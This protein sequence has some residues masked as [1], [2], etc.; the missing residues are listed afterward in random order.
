[1]KNNKTNYEEAKAHRLYPP[2]CLP[3]KGMVTKMIKRL[4]AIVLISTMI[5]ASVDYSVSAEASNYDGSIKYQAGHAA[6][7]KEP[8]KSLESLEVAESLESLEAQDTSKGAEPLQDEKNTKGI[9]PITETPNNRED[10]ATTDVASDFINIMSLAEPDISVPVKYGEDQ[11]NYPIAPYYHDID[12][13]ES[14]ELSSGALNLN[15]V[16]FSLP[17]KDGF[18]FTLNRRYDSSQSNSYVLTPYYETQAP[19]NT[20]WYVEIPVTFRYKRDSGSTG[21]TTFYARTA[22]NL[23]GYYYSD[24]DRARRDRDDLGYFLTEDFVPGEYF[25]LPDGEW[26][27][28]DRVNSFAQ[29]WGGSNDN[30]I[31]TISNK[32]LMVSYLRD[33][34]HDLNTY[35][36][37]QGWNFG[38]PSVEVVADRDKKNN[39]FT[40]NSYLHVGDGRR[41]RLDYSRSGTTRIYHMMYMNTSNKWHNY[42]QLQRDIEFTY[43]TSAAARYPGANHVLAYKDGKKAYFSATEKGTSTSTYHFEDFKLLAMEDRFGNAIK[44][45]LVTDGST[46]GSGTVT[47]SLG[48]LITAT[49]TGSN[50]DYTIRWSFP[51]ENNNPNGASISYRVV[52]N[53]LSEYTD[54]LGNVTRYSYDFQ[55]SPSQYMS[56]VY[57]DK[58]VN[59]WYYPLES[60]THASGLISNYSYTSRELMTNRF[61]G[62]YETA[63][64]LAERSDTDGS[65]VTNRQQ[66][67]YESKPRVLDEIEV[68]SP[69]WGYDSYGFAISTFTEKATIQKNTTREEYLFRFA[70]PT[71]DVRIFEGSS[72]SP[73]ETRT[74]EYN[75]P[76]TV[77]MPTLER[78]TRVEESGSSIVSETRN[79]YDRF[80]NATSSTD[81]M[82][83]ITT[84]TYDA[85]CS[86]PTK[87]TYKKDSATDITEDYELNSAGT[88]VAKKTVT[89]GASIK[90]RTEYLYTGNNLTEMRRY[91]SSDAN[92]APVDNL[93][94]STT[95]VATTYSYANNNA[96]LPNATYNNVFLTGQTVSG[97]TDADGAQA[98]GTAT[99]GTITETYKRDAWG[100]IIEQTDPN[101]NTTKYQL[102]RLGRATL[103]TNPDGST[104]K[105]A[106][107]LTSSENKVVATDENGNDTTYNYNKA[108][109]IIQVLAGSVAMSDFTYDSL[110]RLSR[111]TSYAPSVSYEHYLYDWS[112][113]VKEIRLNTSTAIS[114][115]PLYRETYSYTGMAG[116][117]RQTQKTVEGTSATDPS[118]VTSQRFDLLGRVV[119]ESIGP[120]NYAYTYDSLGN[121]L[122]ATDPLNRSKNFTYDYAGRATSESQTNAGATTYA[123]STYDHL[124]NLASAADFN[125]NAAA[126]QYDRLGRLIVET[127]PLDTTTKSVKKYYYDAAGNVIKDETRENSA[128]G[129]LLSRREYSYDARNRLLDA[130]NYKNASE[131]DTASYQYYP[132]GQISQLTAGGNTTSYEYNRF[133][134]ATKIRDAKN[135][136]EVYTYDQRG[137]LTSKTFRNGNSIEYGYDALGRVVKE[138]ARKSGASS[139]E[140]TTAYSYGLTGALL[141]QSNANLATSFVYNS[142]GQLTRQTDGDATKTYTYDAVG[143]RETFAL[144]QGSTVLSLS[145]DYDDLNRLSQALE[146]SA[147]IA[148]YTYDDN[149]NVKTY[150]NNKNG[151]TTTYSYNRAN[152]VTNIAPN[153][154]SLPSYAYEYRADGNQT[155]KTEALAGSPA[156]VT[157][158]TYDM[159]GRLTSEAVGELTTAYAFDGAGNRDTVTVSG[160]ESYSIKYEYDSLNRL[161]SSAKSEGGAQIVT[162][163]S[164]DANGNTL[165]S[166]V[167]TF[168]PISGA[169]ASYTMEE[170]LGAIEAF[171]YNARDQLIR[172]YNGEAVAE[173][174]YRPD[175]MRHEKTVGGTATRHLWDGANIVAEASA[176]GVVHQAYLRG[177]WL[178]AGKDLDGGAYTMYNHNAHGDVVH[179]TDA[180][181]A[182]IKTY[183]YD[184]FGVEKA[185][186]AADA[187]PFRYCGEYWDKESGTYYLR[188]RYYAPGLGR[189]LSFDTHW[190][191]GNMVYG[192]NPLKWNERQPDTNNPLGLSTYAYKP[193]IY[194]I[195]QSGNLYVYGLNNPVQYID[196][197]GFWVFIYG[198]E[199]AA[200][201][202]YRLSGSTGLMVDGE[203]N[204][205]VIDTGSWVGTGLCGV[206]GGKFVAVFPDAPNISAL[207]GGSFEFGGALGELLYIGI[208]ESVGIETPYHGYMFSIGIG[209]GLPVDAHFQISN[210]Y[211]STSPWRI[212][213]Q[214]LYDPFGSMIIDSVY[215]VQ[216]IKKL[217]NK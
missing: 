163:Y 216:M 36:V 91:Y 116:N 97:V 82:G 70:E 29:Y 135:Q 80:G 189:F 22:Y 127:L 2:S 78:R 194:A 148:S 141:S 17:G 101:G 14:V 28:I 209:A 71:Y 121:R 13:V 106:Y 104:V 180:S 186:D 215:S 192:D 170:G 96:V 48:R 94:A 9:E 100:R 32:Q 150:A 111:A 176:D 212:A 19:N 113:R 52:N 72:S 168:T 165:S 93:G 188:A 83:N 185:P 159:Q 190:N 155:K 50:A 149:S 66:Y 200:Q 177:L 102:D 126:Y 46:G 181:G 76:H 69:R 25:V 54:P 63:P 105:T 44:F 99:N 208:Q 109:D 131:A 118:I 30:G 7:G 10:E 136:D 207:D 174:T 184:A 175:G 198:T 56:Y 166:R 137:V 173:Y 4:I 206:S 73:K 169:A 142:L 154:N 201:F 171:E 161:L 64:F 130:A 37:G 114:G 147:L 21:N 195:K 129:A 47:D 74:Y 51:D 123:R 156:K 103:V 146:N 211:I 202:G 86:I 55:L 45:N 199:A 98:A 27:E 59:L 110:R 203:G 164:Y 1:M 90:E 196:P 205:G 34:N 119:G 153:K 20:Q 62:G 197:N 8:L 49:R 43:D 144:A 5:F 12:S 68:Y 139:I 182:V 193:D 3:Q 132:T 24:K 85:I 38:F 213:V 134:S 23:A 35:G 87:I 210:S 122:S 172:S 157:N 31:K 151:V 39:S 16:D 81:P 160:T 41:I 40:Y 187:N 179:L 217:L 77:T 183:D 33:N 125:G 42:L 133:G 89:E 178:V 115:E 84:A 138:D 26:V 58:G 61:L 112:G 79:A 15:Y 88:L 75:L 204:I 60:I 167:D 140:S 107:T 11:R 92:G 117:I 214:R 191:P 143:N 145:Y 57:G 18:D 158:Y 128:N 108:G 53:R 6:T 95:Y 67:T 124:G 152:L 65:I 162:S 120:N